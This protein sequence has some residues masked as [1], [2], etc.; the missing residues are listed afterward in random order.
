MPLPAFFVR[1][2][3]CYMLSEGTENC[4]PSRDEESGDIAGFWNWVATIC[5]KNSP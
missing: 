4:I 1:V 2:L 5:T 3:R